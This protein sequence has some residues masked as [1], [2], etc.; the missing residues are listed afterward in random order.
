[1][2]LHSFVFDEQAVDLRDFDKIAIYAITCFVMPC[3][4]QQ[5]FGE[6]ILQSG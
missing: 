4:S 5:F 6:R 1:L 2:L 3:G